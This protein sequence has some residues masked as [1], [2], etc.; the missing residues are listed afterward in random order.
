MCGAKIVKGERRIK[1]RNLFQIFFIPNRILS[2]PKIVKGE[3]RSKRE[4]L[5]FKFDYAEPHPISQGKIGQKLF[6]IPFT[7]FPL[8]KFHISVF[9]LLLHVG[10]GRKSTGIQVRKFLSTKPGNRPV[11]TGRE[12]PSMR[13]C[14]HVV[15]P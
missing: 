5:F 2:Y 1:Y 8:Q 3:C 4:N 9:L 15:L 6:H 10:I 14:S 12:A 13:S 7:M 11:S